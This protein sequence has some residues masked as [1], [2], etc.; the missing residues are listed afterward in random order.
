MLTMVTVIGLLVQG[1]N[2]FTFPTP[3]IYIFYILLLLFLPGY[4][5]LAAMDP[6]FVQNHWI[7]RVGLSIVVS[8]VTSILLALFLTFTPLAVLNSV[9]IYILG[10]FTIIFSL[11]AIFR[12]K[13]YHYV[14]FIDSRG[15]Q[16]EFD[17][18]MFQ[19]MRED[20]LKSP[21]IRIEKIGAP[22]PDLDSG[23][24]EVNFDEGDELIRDKL[25]KPKLSEQEQPESRQKQ[26][27]SGQE[28]PESRQ[29]QPDNHKT[30][31]KEV[32]TRTMKVEREMKS[33][34]NLNNQ[35]PGIKPPRRFSYLDLVV[36]LFVTIVSLTFLLEPNLKGSIFIDAVNLILML[37]LPGYA[38][39][40]VI[41]PRKDDLN[42]IT[43]LV[44]SF[45]V[46]YFLTS[47]IGLVL[48][49]TNMGDSLETILLALSVLTLIFIGTA[50]FARMRIP[51]DERFSVGFG[52][53]PS[54]PTSSPSAPASSPSAPST[55]PKTSSNPASSP[56]PAGGSRKRNIMIMGV[57][58]IVALLVAAPTYQMMKPAE[59]VTN[60]ST[61]FYVLGPDGKNISTY[62]SNLT[63]GQTGNVT[64]VLVNHENTTTDYRIVTT[65]NQ[66]VINEINV[67]LNPGE[68]REI[69]YTFTTGE[70]GTKK[71]EFLLYKLPNVTDVYLS[72]NFL[73]NIVE[74]VTG[75]EGEETATDT[76]GDTGGNTGGTQPYVPPYTPPYTPEPEPEPTPEP[77]P[78]PGLD[79]DNF[80]N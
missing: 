80:M 28:Q 8:L 63:P 74:L 41:S 72:Y 70:S 29:K 10:A 59:N 73:V 26:P 46:S 60:P 13:R 16:V 57:I 37:F 48:N 24:Q 68:K 38:L 17:K 35:D 49:Y 4:S 53:S 27:E 14:H 45:G 50:F 21:P 79:L 11:I 6:E 39:M 19:S 62:P 51:A 69:P 36:V 75:T 55:S 65:S 78:E 34:E 12:R 67:T 71:M 31:P 52:G 1:L 42:F 2:L 66:T 61:E 77:T 40:A 76:G 30:S 47:V 58:V 23:D 20:G 33:G 7:K 15:Q 25:D 64:I 3:I 9:T 44:L 43:R 54:T 5:L 32:E 18:G 22:Q 56:S